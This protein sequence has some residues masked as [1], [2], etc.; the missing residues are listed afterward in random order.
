MSEV[1]VD[2]LIDVNKRAVNRH[3]RAIGFEDRL[4]LRDLRLQPIRR[5]VDDDQIPARSLGQQLVVPL[6]LARELIEPGDEARVLDEGVA[7]GRGL[8][9]GVGQQVKPQPELFR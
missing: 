6:R 4:V 2:S 8:D 9:E 1:I 7:R 5:L 3:R